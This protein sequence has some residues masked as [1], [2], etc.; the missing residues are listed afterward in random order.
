MFAYIENIT[1]IKGGRYQSPSSLVQFPCW[2]FSND[3]DVYHQLYIYT[4]RYVQY[5]SD[6]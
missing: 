3:L 2:A 4:Q 5:L 6:F 1:S